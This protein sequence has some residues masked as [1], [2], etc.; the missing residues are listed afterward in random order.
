MLPLLT[1]IVL[2]SYLRRRHNQT[3]RLK[4]KTFSGAGCGRVFWNYK[5]MEPEIRILSKNKKKFL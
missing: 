5:P 4:K 1:L 3:L 2:V